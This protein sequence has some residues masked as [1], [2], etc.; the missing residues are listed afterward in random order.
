MLSR[1]TFHVDT[2]RILATWSASQPLA[3]S[4]AACAHAWAA[5]QAL[6]L[7]QATDLDLAELAS[8]PSTNPALAAVPYS[9][10]VSHKS[11]PSV[12]R[13]TF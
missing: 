3:L 8:T 4:A 1:A 12:V 2:Q 5:G 6:S 11:S 13:V 10:G 9:V 7:D